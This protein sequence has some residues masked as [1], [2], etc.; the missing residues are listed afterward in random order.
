MSRLLALIGVLAVWLGSTAAAR[1]D[2]FG[3][4]SLMS[5][6]ALG[7]ARPQQAEYAHDAA[8]SGNGEY[9]A[10]DGSV[11]GVTGVWRR[12]VA[13]GAIEEVAGGD[14]ELPSVSENGRYISFIST[15]DLVPADEAHGPSV[16]V[17]D[18]APG[19]GEPAYIL[20]SAANGSEKGL[21]Y[22]YTNAAQEEQRFGASAVGRSA[23][24]ANGQEVA[25]VTTAVSNLVAYP[26]LEEE[27]RRRGET[28]KPH[29]PA[30]QVAVRYLQSDTTKLVSGEY[31]E[32]RTSE[33]PVTNASFGA[34]YPGSSK[35]VGFASTPADAYWGEDPP[36]GAAI[37]ADGSTVA[38]MG[39]DVA[40]QAPMLPG[41]DP[42]PLYTEPLW[43]RIAP[44]SETS[45]ER[46]TGGSD[47]SAPGCAASGEQALPEILQ[48]SAADPCQGPFKVGLDA[49]PEGSRGIWSE[50]GGGGEADFVPRLSANGYTV[51]FLGSAVPIAL[52]LGF[53]TEFE[54]EP[55][56]LY[57]ANMQPSL[58][59]RQALTP[60]TQIAGKNAGAGSPVTD[61]DISANGE[62]V[63]FTTRRSEFALGSPAY[64][65][66]ALAE[67]G[68]S[69]LYD[70]DLHDDTL[71]RV[72]H[73][74]EGG[75]SEQAHPS[76]LQCP[77]DED[78]YC[79]PITIGAQSP[80][81]SADGQQVAFSSTASNLV[82]G[83]GNSPSNIL[84][85]PEGPRDGSDAFLV[86]LLPALTL[87]TP[88]TISPAPVVQ[89]V[90]RWRLSATA[91]SRA[92]GSVLLYV[93]VPGQGTLRAK[94]EGAVLA[95]STAGASRR[96]ADRASRHGRTHRS[97]KAA[98]ARR[99]SSRARQAT[100]PRTVS[101]A[102]KR[103]AG[104]QVA[105]LALLLAKPYAAL[106]S[107]SGGFSAN[108]ELTFAA[109]GHP[110]LHQTLQVTFLSSGRA[111]RSSKGAAARHR[112]KHGR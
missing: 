85:T 79:N 82:Y 20:A 40:Q 73:G 56:D 36:P 98:S 50:V 111:H 32:G 17:R 25:F 41:E 91:L 105:Q 3:P 9:V 15:E 103:V 80:S 10:F 104:A 67:P 21:T 74:Y 31:R 30:L 102:S 7:G 5:E 44:G 58:T 94:A 96:H 8:I 13:S 112:G 110:T 100:T 76:L 65:S 49:G 12:D 54:G 72:T 33:A 101:S 88:Q 60:L 86:Q 35:D 109:G 57:V 68:E 45:T 37:S 83:D 108:V 53:G 34:V 51:A 99:G 92:N 64:V 107:R 87:P 59:R 27:E 89:I 6:G 81:L 66:T 78:P 48:Q 29:T 42:A 24:S 39:E 84:G 93:E 23:I 47:P 26:E 38:W 70:V 2:L 52:G 106:A 22:G 11:G 18:M 62:Q 69:E 97:A 63:A 28:P 61:F 77:G 19:P 43:R 1:A 16:W 46:V 95:T 55:A 71:T 14:S 75:P 90:P 4:I